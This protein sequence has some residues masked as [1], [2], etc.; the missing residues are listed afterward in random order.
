MPPIPNALA[1]DFTTIVPALD[2]TADARP[3]RGFPDP[4]STLF[5]AVFTAFITVTTPGVYTLQLVANDGAALYLRNGSRAG[6][7]AAVVE[8]WSGTQPI[9]REVF[10][11]AGT[12]EVSGRCAFHTKIS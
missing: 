10:L 8:S 9:S 3:W 5:A 12:Y 6:D 4:L 1:A 11:Q 7:F 2:L